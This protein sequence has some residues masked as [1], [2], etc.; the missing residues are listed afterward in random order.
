MCKLHL[1]A[2]SHSYTCAQDGLDTVQLAL[3]V[4]F[5]PSTSKI[6]HLDSWWSSPAAT[7]A[8]GVL[9]WSTMHTLQLALC[10]G[11]GGDCMWW[12]LYVV[13]VAVYGGHGH[14]HV[15]VVVAITV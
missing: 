11:G 10:G 3:V 7:C 5:L 12:W 14:L 6:L 15:E 8:G 2:A 9:P 1:V 4:F 13:V